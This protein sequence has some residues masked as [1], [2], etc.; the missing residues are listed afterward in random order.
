MKWFS[1]F[2]LMKRSQAS[3]Q[4]SPDQTTMLPSD[5]G[6]IMSRQSAPSS[7]TDAKCVL[8][9][10]TFGQSDL[11]TRRWHSGS[12]FPAEIFSG[13][14]INDFSHRILSDAPVRDDASASLSFAARQI[15][16]VP[17][18]PQV[19]IKQP[20]LEKATPVAGP[21][22]CTVSA[23]RP[24]ATFQSFTVLS[25]PAEARVLESCVKANDI[26]AVVCP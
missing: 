9:A 15:L 26:T 25:W 20:S 13:W 7:N 8:F 6:L 16:A 10:R 17:S 24:V 23:V 12:I 11:P 14:Q 2:S 5:Q 4:N 22:C 21:R 1:V 3:C 18:A 19:A